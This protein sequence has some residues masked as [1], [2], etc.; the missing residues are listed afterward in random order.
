LRSRHQT[1]ELGLDFG[2]LF[3]GEGH[4]RRPGGSLLDYH[5]RDFIFSRL[6]LGL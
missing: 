4:K 3:I 2:D 6:D 1:I 5:V